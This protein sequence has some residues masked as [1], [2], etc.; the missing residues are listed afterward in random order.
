MDF[1]IIAL[2]ILG[3]MYYTGKTLSKAIRGG[4]GSGAAMYIE[5]LDDMD[6]GGW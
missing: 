3:G 4:L 5:G 2:I 1:I 6:E